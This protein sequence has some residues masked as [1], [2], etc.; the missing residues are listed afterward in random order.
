MSAD[1]FSWHIM[2][3]LLASPRWM[4]GILLNFP[5][6]VGQ[7]LTIKKCLAQN[8]HSAEVEKS[9]LEDL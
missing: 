5:H 4:L 7:S 1:I 3:M 6:Y 9:W 8:I 2:E